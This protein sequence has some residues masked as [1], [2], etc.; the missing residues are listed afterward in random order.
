MHIN[1][2]VVDLICTPT[3]SGK[4]RDEAIRAID[5]IQ[6]KSVERVIYLAP[7]KHLLQ[8]FNKELCEISKL[9]NADLKR[10][11]IK[12]NIDMFNENQKNI[13]ELIDYI[14]IK[15]LEQL[16]KAPD[17]KKANK[18]REYRNNIKILNEIY[19]T[20]R[21][22]RNLDFNEKENEKIITH[23]RNLSKKIIPKGKSKE[24]KEILD[25]LSLVFTNYRIELENFDVIMLTF[26]KTQFEISPRTK[27]LYRR[28]PR[29][30]KPDRTDFET[31]DL[32]DRGEPEEEE[33]FKCLI[34]G[35]LVIVDEFEY[36]RGTIDS[37]L[38]TNCIE[39]SLTELTSVIS[40]L[41]NKNLDTIKNI[42]D[43]YYRYIKNEDRTNFN[44]YYLEYK[45]IFEFERIFNNARHI[46]NEYNFERGILSGDSFD[47]LHKTSF[48][49]F[50]LN[51]SVFISE[52]ESQVHSTFLTKKINGNS[53]TF[54]RYNK[55]VFVDLSTMNQKDSKYAKIVESRDFSPNIISINNASAKILDRDFLRN[56]V[57]PFVN[58]RGGIHIVTN[59]HPLITLEDISYF[60]KLCSQVGLKVTGFF[61]TPEDIPTETESFLLNIVKKRETRSKDKLTRDLE[62][63]FDHYS[64]IEESQNITVEKFETINLSTL[65]KILTDIMLKIEVIEEKVGDKRKIPSHC[66]HFFKR[67]DKSNKYM[68]YALD[69]CDMGKMSFLKSDKIKPFD[70]KHKNQLY[71]KIGNREYRISRSNIRNVVSDKYLKEQYRIQDNPH[72][73]FSKIIDFCNSPEANNVTNNE[74]LEFIK[75]L[76]ESKELKTLARVK[77]RDLQNSF[78]YG[79][80]VTTKKL[81][82]AKYNKEILGRIKKDFGVDLGTIRGWYPE[83]SRDEL[84]GFT[85]INY[86]E[87]QGDLYYKTSSLELKDYSI[88]NNASYIK[89]E[90]GSEVKDKIISLLTSSSYC[91]VFKEREPTVSNVNSNFADSLKY[92]NEKFFSRDTK[93][94][95]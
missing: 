92:L 24:Y 78:D 15:L 94:T 57:I 6:N 61:D 56:T 10:I 8:Q 43:T 27:F 26:K 80:G 88:Q 45:E 39:G 81:I 31:D 3:G 34:E 83:K 63:K 12:S 41:S 4:T 65:S 86:F 58:D 35:A 14:K 67:I 74:S 53:L 18:E 20:V 2:S 42:I 48:C 73:V 69:I 79:D 82:K 59:K 38:T 13:P 11:I 47:R 87:H 33:L 55:G 50:Y 44:G 84:G 52:I 71:L 37:T 16:M 28:D 22:N 90:S 5:S 25:R 1:D 30:K 36:Y 29:D 93:I 91:Y 62:D 7:R 49:S 89:I 66:L 19:E 64:D 51:G 68:S 76:K 72:P 46:V 85:R 9:K 60:K 23:I 40:A 32:L 70:K 77:I 75:H 17:K 95:I 54:K 21:Q